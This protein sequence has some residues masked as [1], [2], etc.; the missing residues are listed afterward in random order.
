MG[1][2][3]IVGTQ[4]APA[5]AV[6]VAGHEVGSPVRNTEAGTTLQ[7]VPV[8]YSALDA[9]IAKAQAAGFTVNVT[10]AAPTQVANT[11]VDNAI[12][13]ANQSVNEQIKKAPGC[14]S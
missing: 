11:E 1:T 10:D 14:A 6:Q 5:L 12:S 3:T 4:I 9:E 8:D 2:L 7:D 13:T